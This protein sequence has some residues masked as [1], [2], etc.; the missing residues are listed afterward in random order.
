MSFIKHVRIV[1]VA[2][3]GVGTNNKLYAFGTAAYDVGKFI[4][5]KT[6]YETQFV[7]FRAYGDAADY[8]LK[9]DKKFFKVTADN[10][11]V[12]EPFQI[13]KDNKTVANLNM[14][15]TV[16]GPAETN[17]NSGQ[18]QSQQ[19][20]QQQNQTQSQ[21]QAQTQAQP[22][23]QTQDQSD[24]FADQS[25]STLVDDDPFAAGAGDPFATG[26]NGY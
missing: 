4:D 11:Y 6:V 8:L 14:T 5:K 19:Q 10:I 12:G 7:D 16:V 1:K 20:S 17:F 2:S 22:Q 9:S 3:S 21:P 25:A 15:F 23:A 24:P 18:Q 26:S 13:K